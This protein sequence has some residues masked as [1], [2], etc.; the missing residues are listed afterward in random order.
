MKNSTHLNAAKILTN[1]LMSKEGQVALFYANDATP[2][3]KGLQGKEF[4][5]FPEQ[6][7]G[8]KKAIAED[9]DGAEEDALLKYWEGLWLKSSGGG[10][11]R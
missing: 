3:H 7:Q 2:A 4:I 11:A 8:K 5:A 1:W 6:I 10:T 9:R